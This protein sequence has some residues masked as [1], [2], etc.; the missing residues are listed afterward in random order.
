MYEQFI[1]QLCVDEILEDITDTN[2]VTKTRSKICEF[3]YCDV[4]YNCLLSYFMNGKCMLLYVKKYRP[5]T[6]MHNNSEN[7]C[8]II[9]IIIMVG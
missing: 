6:C 8:I 9:I 2:T 7:E 1:L 5:K 3:F 4:I